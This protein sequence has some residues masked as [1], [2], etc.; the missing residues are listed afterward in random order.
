MGRIVAAILLAGLALSGTPAMASDYAFKLHNRSTGWTISGFYTFQD[1]VWSEN[2]LDS[3]IPA[4]SSVRMDWKSNAGNCVVPF[5]VR[6]V[7]YGAEDFSI[8]WCKSVGNIY[9][10]D[11]G[12]SWD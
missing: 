3:Q 8:D 9:M 5:R 11:A 6:W 12:F 7:D 2:W 1:G 4:G 10:K